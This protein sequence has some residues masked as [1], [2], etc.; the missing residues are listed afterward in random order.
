MSEEIPEYISRDFILLPY[1]SAAEGNN[2]Y[3]S[4]E[5]SEL[6]FDSCGMVP[7]IMEQ[8]QIHIHFVFKKRTI[9]CQTCKGTDS[10][11]KAFKEK[12]GVPFDS[13][14]SYRA[15][16]SKLCLVSVVFNDLQAYG[17]IY[18]VQLSE[19]DHKKFQNQELK[20][21]D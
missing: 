6:E 5:I 12:L 21:Q 14:I 18:Y 11:A 4:D 8:G 10:I 15:V 3:E 1:L 13:D 7:P 16:N 2:G 19:D 17:G 9:R 20:E